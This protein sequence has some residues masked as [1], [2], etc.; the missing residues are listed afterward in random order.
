MNFLSALGTHRLSVTFAKDCLVSPCFLRWL[1]WFGKNVY[2]SVTPRPS[3]HLLSPCRKASVPTPGGPGSSSLG[4]QPSPCWGHAGHR[5]VLGEQ[6]GAGA[7][8]GITQNL[9]LVLS[10]GS[11]TSGTVSGVMML[12]VWGVRVRWGPLCLSLP[13][14]LPFPQGH[15]ECHQI[16]RGLHPPCTAEIVSRI[17]ASQA[18]R[19]SDALV[20][21]AA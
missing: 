1:L 2:S 15:R 19:C 7:G 5:A 6:S 11:N 12:W 14:P 9:S 3:P 4:V 13:A 8:H 20:K 16:P 17:D 18:V 10:P 21:R